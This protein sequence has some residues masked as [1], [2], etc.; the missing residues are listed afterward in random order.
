MSTC[1]NC[2]RRMM[3]RR[4]FCSEDCADEWHEARE[5]KE[6]LEDEE[7]EDSEISSREF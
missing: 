2:G 1:V 5:P 6:K 4:D 3:Y 7:N